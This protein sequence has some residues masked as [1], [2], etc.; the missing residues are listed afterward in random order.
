ML[1]GRTRAYSLVGDCASSQKYGQASLN[2]F[3]EMTVNTMEI[4]MWER[5]GE[6]AHGINRKTRFC[7]IYKGTKK[8]RNF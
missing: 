3:R 4:D 2:S 7:G 8:L 6:R 1:Q 5:Q